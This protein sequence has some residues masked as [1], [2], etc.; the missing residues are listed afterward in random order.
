VGLVRKSFQN[1]LHNL[2]QRA[3]DHAEAIHEN[4]DTR[5][6]QEMLDDACL[7]F[8]EMCPDTP[9]EQAGGRER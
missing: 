1:A 3:L 2:K 6:T 4:G 5:T 8:D 9:P 7:Y